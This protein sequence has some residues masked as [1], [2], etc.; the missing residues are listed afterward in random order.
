[1]LVGRKSYSI[2]FTSFLVISFFLS[3]KLIL[4]FP[5]YNSNILDQK[6]ESSFFDGARMIFFDL[7]VLDPPLIFYFFESMETVFCC[8]FD[9][10]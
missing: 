8:Y 3:G 7:I 4:S 1:M 5:F 6:L 10:S 9:Q 2:S